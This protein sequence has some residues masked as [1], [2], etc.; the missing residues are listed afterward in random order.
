MAEKTT[1]AH[2]DE[3]SRL[4][5]RIQDLES[6]LHTS[7]SSSNHESRREECR[8][9]FDSIRDASHSNM[10]QVTRTVRGISMASVEGLRSFGDSLSAFGDRV[11]TR[12]TASEDTSTRELGRRL[13]G[14]IAEGVAEFFDRMVDVPAKAA[15]RFSKAYREGKRT[16]WTDDEDDDNAPRTHHTDRATAGKA[17]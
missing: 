3:I 2:E 17:V 1:S 15:D 7:K 6:E 12:N 5:A 11:I 13:P 8:R 16:E 14:D 4:K 9:T 10:D